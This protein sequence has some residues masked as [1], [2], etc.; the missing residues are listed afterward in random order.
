MQPI[1]DKDFD[2]LFKNAFED[3][4]FTP[5]KDLWG[6]IECEIE[7]KKKRIIP[8]YWLSAAAVA[9]IATV[10]ILVYQQQEIKPKL[11]GNVEPNIETPAVSDPAFVDSIPTTTAPI[12]KAAVITPQQ[13]NVA[14]GTLAG[15]KIN[16]PVKPVEERKIIAAPELQKQEIIIAKVEEPKKDLRTQIEQ[17]VAQQKEET[18]LAANTVDTD[19]VVEEITPAENKSIRNVGDVVNLIMNKVDKR[20]DKFIQ[21]RTDDDDSSVSAINIGPF[22]FGKKNRK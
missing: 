11:A 7:P 3:A 15:R 1:Q 21:F 22:K 18:V 12:E 17:A 4:E 5:S 8:V 19:E 2:Q 14:A 9:I 6:G 16:E 13:R 20:K 10:G